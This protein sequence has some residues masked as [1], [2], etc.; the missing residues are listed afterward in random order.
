MNN[1][2]MDR[3]NISKRYSNPMQNVEYTSSHRYFR[4][5]FPQIYTDTNKGINN[6]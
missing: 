3:N 6:Q 2:N 4:H 1:S 5:R